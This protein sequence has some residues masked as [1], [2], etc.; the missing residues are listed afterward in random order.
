MR[1]HTEAGMRLTPPSPSDTCHWSLGPTGEP[2]LVRR[3]PPRPGWPGQTWPASFDRRRRSVQT[4]STFRYR[5]ATC[6]RIAVI[7]STFCQRF[8]SF[9][10]IFDVALSLGLWATSFSLRSVCFV[11]FS[12]D[13]GRFV[14]SASSDRSGALVASFE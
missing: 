11:D 10:D 14:V 8:S 6:A 5:F 12:L 4:S 1:L 2:S 9:L 7:L 3:T 13:L